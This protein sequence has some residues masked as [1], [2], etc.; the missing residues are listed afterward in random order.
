MGKI[1]FLFILFCSS[2]AQA[3][4]E[5]QFA[6]RFLLEEVSAGKPWNYLGV[7]SLY[8]NETLTRKVMV[9]RNFE[10]KKKLEIEAVDDFFILT[11]PEGE[12]TFRSMAFMGFTRAEIQELLETTSY[13]KTLLNQFLPIPQAYGH[14]GCASHNPLL[15]GLDELGDFF[16]EGS[17]RHVMNCLGPLLQGAWESTGGMVAAA[18]SGIQSLVTNPRAFWRARVAQMNN[19]ESFI[20]NFQ[21]K[22]GQLAGS[23]M[24]LPDAVKATLLCSFAGGLGADALLTILT[25]GAGAIA[26]LARVD[27]YLMKVVRLERVLARLNQ[28]GRL[29]SIS[30]QFLSSLVTAR[31]ADRVIDE[32]NA[33]HRHG[34]DDVV[35]GAMSCAI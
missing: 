8:S 25:G 7:H 15:N 9:V 4:S 21:S 30:P 35:T 18:A 24:R 33:F 1:I 29:D 5:H 22:M 26:V 28:L 3:L 32:I 34:M 2:A 17:G 27:R 10:G 23:L 12:N 20:R 19:L 11:L 14:G 13:I 16:S 6:S 31:H